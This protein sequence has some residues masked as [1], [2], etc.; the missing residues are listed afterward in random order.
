[1]SKKGGGSQETQA[2]RTQSEISRQLYEQSDPLRRAMIA[3][4]MNF[5]G[6]DPNQTYQSPFD[7]SSALKVPIAGRAVSSEGSGISDI[8]QRGLEKKLQ[9]QADQDMP[10]FPSISYGNIDASVLPG[11]QA[12]KNIIEGQAK[13]SRAS[14]LAGG[15]S[16]GALQDILARSEDDRARSLGV[17]GSELT[18]QQLNQALSLATGGI[19]GSQQGLS[20]VISAQAE[21]A[22]AEQQSKGAK[23]QGAGSMAAAMMMKNAAGGAGAAGGASAAAGAAAA[24]SDRRIKSNVRTLAIIDNIKYYTYNYFNDSTVMAGVMA[25]EVDHIPNAVFEIN[26][27]QHVNYGAL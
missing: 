5:L 9:N 25:D 11:F 13:R 15:A 8:L 3:L 10:L 27:I 23:G 6:L 4:N 12:G 19:A 2:T 1:M 18:Q 26:N 20:S 21:Q 24:A 14:A 22:A 7:K 17:L 16:G